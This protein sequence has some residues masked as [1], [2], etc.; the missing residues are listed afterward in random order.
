MIIVVIVMV[1]VIIVLITSCRVRA[2]AEGRGAAY[3]NTKIMLWPE[4]SCQSGAK[5]KNGVEKAEVRN[6]SRVRAGRASAMVYF[7]NYTDPTPHGYDGISRSVVW[8]F[9]TFFPPPNSWYPPLEPPIFPSQNV[10]KNR[11]KSCARGGGRG[12]SVDV[13]WPKW[14]KMGSKN[15]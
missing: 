13:L 14:A 15:Q 4:W 7:C 8:I 10:N 1:I 9:S 6:S 5:S 12:D 11:W 3:L 2:A